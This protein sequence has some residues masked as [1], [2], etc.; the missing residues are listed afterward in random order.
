[1]C[2]EGEVRTEARVAA[3]ALTTD[4]LRGA[5]ESSGRTDV[6]LVRPEGG[7]LTGAKVEPWVRLE[8]KADAG[9]L[10]LGVMIFPRVNLPLRVRWVCS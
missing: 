6:V 4:G 2:D 5:V 8:A 9:G 7:R 10:T 3:A 1:M